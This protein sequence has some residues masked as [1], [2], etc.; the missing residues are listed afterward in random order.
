VRHFV[1]SAE[2]FGDILWSLPT[3]REIARM[4]GAPVDFYMMPYYESLV[5]LLEGQEY[6]ERAGV[7]PDWLRTNSNCGDQPW[8]PPKEMESRY[9]KFFHLTYKGHPGINAPDMP[10]IE[11]IA[12]QQGLKLKEP[13]IPFLQASSD[14]QELATPIHFSTGQF[15]EVVRENR[16]VAYAFNEQYEA[17]K[18]QFF[19][20]LWQ[21]M[22]GT[23]IEFFNVN[24][25]GWKEAA[26]VI[27]QSLI[28]VGCRSAC[29][30]L[31]MGL[32]KESITFEPHPARHAKGFLGKVFGCPY[33]GQETP[34][35]FAMA[36]AVASD[37]AASLIKA[38]MT[39]V[40][41]V[42]T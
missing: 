29:W 24:T 27:S 37:V 39:R 14:V 16:L 35:P 12:Y 10:L 30:V 33:G 17:E 8:Q 9:K 21:K 11:F 4:T 34:L 32:G 25:V 22:Q 31:A 20:G 19:E 15:M 6:I 36:P 18:K 7:I 5:P 41:E 13:V 23:G 38:K 2:N 1:L 42:V 26:W 3:A 40:Q 28:Y